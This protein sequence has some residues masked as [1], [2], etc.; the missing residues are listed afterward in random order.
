MYAVVF[1]CVA[2]GINN[3]WLAIAATILY[4]VLDDISDSLRSIDSKTPGKNYNSA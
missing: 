4:G 1:F 2:Y 3:W